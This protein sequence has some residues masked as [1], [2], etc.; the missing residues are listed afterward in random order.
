MK[1]I[2]EKLPAVC[3]LVSPKPHDGQVQWA[4]RFA[5]CLAGTR[6]CGYFNDKSKTKGTEI[7]M[8]E[9]ELPCKNKYVFLG[10]IHMESWPRPPSLS[11]MKINLFSLVM[12]WNRMCAIIFCGFL[13]TR[14]NPKTAR[15][16]PEP[17][18]AQ[19]RL[20]WCQLRSADNVLSALDEN[21]SG[22]SFKKRH[23]G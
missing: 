4:L 5:W 1:T 13:M 11:P 14:I 20:V 9:R 6:G 15:T 18:H 22:S 2:L 23:S 7:Q 10:K 8:K 21:S 17:W 12:L 19:N 16:A 3:S